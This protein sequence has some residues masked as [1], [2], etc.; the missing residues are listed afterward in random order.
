MKQI[1]IIL[2]IILLAAIAVYLVKEFS[3]SAH[4]VKGRKKEG[5][6][7]VLSD[8]TDLTGGGGNVYSGAVRK[9]KKAKG[10]VES[11]QEEILSGYRQDQKSIKVNKSQ[12][13][14]R[15]EQEKEQWYQDAIQKNQQNEQG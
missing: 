14:L 11:R 4:T 9:A 13:Q 12:H 1:F 5:E 2:L 7:D 6:Q 8:L 10:A 3:E 15:K